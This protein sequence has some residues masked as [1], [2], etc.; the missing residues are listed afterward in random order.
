LLQTEIKDYRFFLVVSV[1]FISAGPNRFFIGVSDPCNFRQWLFKP[2]SLQL[3]DTPTQEEISDH[4]R[5]LF[6]FVFFRMII[7]TFSLAP[8]LIFFFFREASF[9]LSYL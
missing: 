1:V 6:C 5:F 4:F 2:L 8:F 9:I 3:T 7:R